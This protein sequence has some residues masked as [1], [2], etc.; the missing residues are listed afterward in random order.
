MAKV[1][2]SDS[3]MRR[4]TGIP[5]I[6]VFNSLYSLIVDKVDMLQYWRGQATANN[7]KYQAGKRKKPGPHRKLSP[8][9]EF[10]L[11]MVRLR[12]GMLTSVLADLFGISS[13]RVSQTFTTWINFLHQILKSLI[14][15][16]SKS[17]VQRHMPASFKKMYPN[18]R[19]I[20]DCT[21]FF[22]QKPSNTNAQSVTYSSYKSHNTA[23]VL[24]A[25]SPT[26]AFTFVSE[27]WG[28]NVSDRF[29][30]KHSGFL[31]LI[32]EGDDI[33]ADRGFIIRD[34]LLERKATLNMPPF[35]RKVNVGN[36]KKLNIAEIKQTRKIARLRIHVE[37]AI[38]RLKN[39]T[40]LSNTIPINCH[41]LLPQMIVVAAGMCNLLPPLVQ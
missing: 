8:K 37:R 34:M 41:A 11:T 24:V 10:V 4:Y 3:S 6:V 25:V 38:E 21:E 23:K 2:K 16:P 26:G 40:L 28:G 39:F 15:W 5:T 22:I 1:F 19:A 18:T 30:T 29:I 9:E 32:E 13:S 35:T 14:K 12:T 33:M 17:K 31:D 27:P 7:I 36:R 20:I